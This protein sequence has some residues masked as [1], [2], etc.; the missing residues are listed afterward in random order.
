MAEL[1]HFELQPFFDSCNIGIS[2]VPV[3]DYY[4]HQ[5]VTKTYEYIMSGLVC[6]GTGTYENEIVINENNGVL[7]A[8]N[9][10]S[11]A[12]A[13]KKISMNRGKYISTTIRNTIKNHTWESIVKTKLLPVLEKTSCS[14]NLKRL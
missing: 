13:L 7:C 2:Y 9:P 10:E 12:R 3:T 1:P 6:L 8:D 5:P 11:F 4:N 14:N